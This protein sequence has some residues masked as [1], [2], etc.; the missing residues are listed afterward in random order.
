MAI[1]S[2]ALYLITS[3][4]A[5]G[6]MESVSGSEFFLCGE[7]N[8]TETGTTI[9]VEESPI[10]LFWTFSFGRFGSKTPCFETPEMR[11]EEVS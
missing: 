8:L 2:L 7:G 3:V 6:E 9:A 11:W 10:K 4:M 1:E 5:L